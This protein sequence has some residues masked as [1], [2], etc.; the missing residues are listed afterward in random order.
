MK[1]LFGIGYHTKVIWYNN[2]DIGYFNYMVNVLYD[3]W[4]IIET[5]ISWQI[6]M[7][8]GA[9]LT[10]S[11]YRWWKENKPFLLPPALPFPFAFVP[12]PSALVVSK[13][14]KTQS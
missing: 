1:N 2:F 3:S 5:G 6:N 4:W 9:K 7:L 8:N 10:V 11:F 12:L 14:M 13:K